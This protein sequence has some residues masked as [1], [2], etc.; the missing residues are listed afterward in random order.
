M[1]E[2]ESMMDKSVFWAVSIYLPMKLRT[3]P[4]SV[5]TLDAL[6]LN[7]NGFINDTEHNSVGERSS[8]NQRWGTSQ[9]LTVIASLWELEL[10][11][12][13]FSFIE[14]LAVPLALASC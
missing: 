4:Y 5:G 7:Q 11:S 9:Q 1:L 12:G 14:E 8:S 3:F 2:T 6:S 10:L 13:S